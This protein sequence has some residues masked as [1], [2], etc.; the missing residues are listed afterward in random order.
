[1]TI[2]KFHNPEHANN[3][4]IVYYQSNAACAA[5]PE[6]QHMSYLPGGPAPTFLADK[7]VSQ[8]EWDEL[9]TGIQGFRGVASSQYVCEGVFH[10]CCTRYA[11]SE[12]WCECYSCCF[13]CCVSCCLT[14]KRDRFEQKWCQQLMEKG[15]GLAEDGVDLNGS[16]FPDPWDCCELLMGNHPMVRYFFICDYQEVEGEVLGAPA[17]DNMA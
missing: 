9:L 1:M 3:V 4:V 11:L 6:D 13:S 17:Q 5:L 10:C 7:G 2:E 15:L 8:N 14:R 12:M 16:Q